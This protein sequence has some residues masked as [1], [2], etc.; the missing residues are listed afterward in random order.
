LVFDS[1]DGL[2]TFFL[3]IFSSIFCLVLDAVDCAFGIG[4]FGR[5]AYGVFGLVSDDCGTANNVTV[6]VKNLIYRQPLE[7]CTWKKT[8]TSPSSAIS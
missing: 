4:V 1:I 3:N 6:F 7:L 5:F 8:L 2:F